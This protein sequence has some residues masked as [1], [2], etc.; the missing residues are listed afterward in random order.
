M[1]VI[2]CPTCQKERI[3]KAQLTKNRKIPKHF[4]H[5]Y[6]GELNQRKRCTNGKCGLQFETGPCVG[7]N[8]RYQCGNPESTFNNILREDKIDSM[9][10][11]G[12][13]M[14]PEDAQL[15]DNKVRLV[16]TTMTWNCLLRNYQIV[17]NNRNRIYG[18]IARRIVTHLG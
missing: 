3:G 4:A 5:D 15:C 11:R 8:T 12:F 14:P 13:G 10:H 16:Q 6:W 1:H 2:N 7:N 18:Q 17:R 9:T